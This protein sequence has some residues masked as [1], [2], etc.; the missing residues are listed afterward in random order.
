M[1]AGLLTLALVRT[2]PLAKPLSEGLP[3]HLAAGSGLTRVANTLHIIA[4]DA[5]DVAVFKAD[6]PDEE[7]QLY[8]LF[9]RPP[10]PHDHKERKKL[11][12]DL[13]SAS[14]LWQ[15]DQAYWVALGSGSSEARMRGVCV[16]LDPQGQPGNSVEFGLEPLYRSLQQRFPDLNIEGM[17]PVIRD[18]RLRLAQRGN[19]SLAQNALID[20]DLRQA[21]EQARHG[22]SWGPELV[23]QIQPL[24]LPSLPGSRGPVPLTITDLTP[25]DESRCLFTAAA[26]DTDNPYDDGQVLGSHIGVLE[27]DGTVSRIEPVDLPVKLEGICLNARVGE[28]VQALVVTDGDNPEESASVYETWLIP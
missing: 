2:L 1:T 13:E 9:Q 4:D 10:L 8:R 21:L 18:G 6:A 14:V 15:G 26:E 5:L 3:C 24:Q 28:K 20:L 16:T 19:S 12:P 25:L 11:K 27:A 7:G 22:Q 17:A 23:Q